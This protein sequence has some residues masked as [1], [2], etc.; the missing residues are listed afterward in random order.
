[1]NNKT[2]KEFANYGLEILK[3]SVL[4]VLYEHKHALRI[5]DIYPCLNI[6]RI[7]DQTG[8]K[9]NSDYLIDSILVHLANDGHAKYTKT[10]KW[11][12]TEEGVKF[13]EGSQ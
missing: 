4:S 10:N 7:E 11:Q 5:A 2:R 6:R 3:R 9:A 8:R 1:M 13:I 12:I